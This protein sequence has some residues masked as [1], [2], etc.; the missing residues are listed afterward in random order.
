MSWQGTIAELKAWL[1]TQEQIS[2]EDLALL[3]SDTRTGVQRLLLQW[4]RQQEM[5]RKEAERVAM[6]WNYERT[7]RDRGYEA[8]VGVDEAGRGPLAG[9]VVAAAVVLPPDFEGTGLDDSKRLT[10]EKRLL[11]RTRIEQYA[12]GW[13]VG[14][15]DA[16]YID[17]HNILKATHEAMRRAIMELKITPDVLLIDAVK[18]ADTEVKQES[19]IKGDQLSVSIAAASIIAKTTRDALMKEAALSYPQYGL[20][21]HMGYGTAEHLAAIRK[22]G[23]TPLHRM[24]FAPVAEWADHTQHV[25]AKSAGE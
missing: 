12:R 18:L 20:D 8:I 5:E 22:W 9:P 11:L 1:A 10:E 19:I 3:Q 24:S 4:Q 6:M 25:K 15:V 2:L 13:G 17:E 16:A 23:P 7:Y 14:I 21:K